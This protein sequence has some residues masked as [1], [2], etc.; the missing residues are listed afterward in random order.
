MDKKP[1][2]LKKEETISRLTNLV[3]A[4]SERRLTN[5]PSMLAEK[6]LLSE[7]ITSIKDL[8]ELIKFCNVDEFRFHFFNTSA[9]DARN[10][11]PNN[12]IPNIVLPGATISVSY[13]NESAWEMFTSE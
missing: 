10:N 7:S 11:I 5:S 6:N 2:T 8:I 9:G 1:I 12:N 4:M 13:N 3:Y